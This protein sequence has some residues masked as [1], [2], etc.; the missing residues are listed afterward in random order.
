M[1]SSNTTNAYLINGTLKE[2]AQ[3]AS[4]YSFFSL[5]EPYG[6]REVW[7]AEHAA[8]YNTPVKHPI[9]DYAKPLAAY[10]D[11][12]GTMFVRIEL[13]T[14]YS[15]HI[16]DISVSLLNA[17]PEFV[18][19]ALN[20]LFKFQVFEKRYDLFCKAMLVQRFEPEEEPA[21]DTP[22]SIDGTSLTGVHVEQYPELSSSEGPSVSTEDIVVDEEE[23]SFDDA[24]EDQTEDEARLAEIMALT[25]EA[26]L[27]NI[28]PTINAMPIFMSSTDSPEC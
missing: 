7:D 5:T 15:K 8:F 22:G 28:A 14:D 24:E 10:I 2:V 1:Y 9:S 20:S 12:C 13:R 19:Q 21:V 25:P 27:H 11:K 23:G 17:H 6:L 18:C 26:V 16:V 4:P 3:P